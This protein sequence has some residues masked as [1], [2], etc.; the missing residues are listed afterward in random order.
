[1]KQILVLGAG[2]VVRPL[3]RYLLDQPNFYV[4]VASRTLRKAAALINNHPKGQAQELDISETARLDE[5]ISRV[6]LVISL[7]P[8]IH[9]VSVAQICIKYRKPMVTTSYVSD[10]M[11]ALD[12]EAKKAGIIILNEIGLDPG[13]DHMSAMR[14]I[15]RIQNNGGTVKS[16]SSYCGGLPAP[17]AN[18][19]P[20][21]YKFSWSPRG[22]VLAA[23]NE[24]RYLK[25][26]QE[27]VIPGKELFDHYS[28]I[29]IEGLGDFEGYPNRNSFPYIK[30]YGISTTE[31]MFRGTLRNLG[32]CQTWKKISEIGLLDEKEMDNL[33][34]LTF[35][36]FL[37]RLINGPVQPNLKRVLA[38]YLKIDQDSKVIKRLEWLG[39]LG[40]EPLPL[41]RGSPLDI[42]AARLWTKLQYQA[43]ERDMIILLHEFIAEY[44]KRREKITSTLIDFGIPHGDSAMARTVGLPAAIATKLILQGR[45]RITGIQIPVIPLIYEPI[46]QELEQLGITFKEKTEVLKKLNTNKTE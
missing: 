18:T 9:H 5:L 16:F 37:W 2:L 27:V 12:A 35:K 29:T 42:L 1:M 4:R 21:G 45:M 19:N 31:T 44:S 43:G 32:W 24:A 11:R 17:E 28:M 25:D 36:D 3:V 33:K 20:F 34:G 26:Q 13:I 46:L 10:A 23:K 7:L 8:Y 30:T 15:H 40:D 14:I 38:T 6:D 39:L 41:E 22:V